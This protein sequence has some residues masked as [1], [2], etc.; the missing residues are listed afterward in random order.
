[1][2]LPRIDYR[3]LATSMSGVCVEFMSTGKLRLAGNGEAEG[4][5]WR[6]RCP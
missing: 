3:V 6:F 1:V 5:L 4:V 2:V